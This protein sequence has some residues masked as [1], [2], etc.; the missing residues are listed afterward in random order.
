VKF[1]NSEKGYGFISREQGDDVFVHYSNIQGSGYRSL[2]EGQRVEFDVAPGRKG[3]EAQNV[4]ALAV[5]HTPPPPPLP[6]RHFLSS[7]TR[8][9]AAA[10]QRCPHPPKGRSPL[11]ANRTSFEKLQRDRA[12][13]AKAAAKR[14]RRQDRTPEDETSGLSDLSHGDPSRF[15]EGEEIP[16]D[17]LLRM[18]ASIHEQFEAG[19]ITFE[20]FEERK[21]ELFARISVD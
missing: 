20:E 18:V 1:F 7:A 9:P 3:E 17:E 12:K 4:R 11:G 19:T 14:E 10:A 5:P 8:R 16:A 15:A 6:L 2:E 13:K 21:T